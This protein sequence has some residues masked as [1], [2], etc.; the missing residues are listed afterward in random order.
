[1]VGN[2]KAKGIAL[3]SGSGGNGRTTAALNLAALLA[4]KGQKVLLFDMCFGWGGLNSFVN[5]VPD[6]EALLESEEPETLAFSAPA[7]FDIL[8]CNPPSFLCPGEEELKKIGWMAYYMG[9]KYH[10]IIFD[11]PSGGHPLA[12][13][14]AGLSESVFLFSRPEASSVELSYCLLKSLHEEGIFSRVK[15]AFSFVESFQHAASLKIRF[16]ILTRQFLNIQL[17]DGGFIC[18]RNNDEE[19]FSFREISEQTIAS[20]TNL[21]LNSRP[22]FQNA[23]RMGT[24]GRAI[25]K[26]N[27]KDDKR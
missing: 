13:L 16:D 5:S 1:M 9:F 24:A 4:S 8:T 27:S 6:Y 14:A 18:R 2:P 19:D 25:P 22:A 21:N 23:T 26:I 7:G 11:P 12:L 10:D 20:V 17:A 3:L 15:T